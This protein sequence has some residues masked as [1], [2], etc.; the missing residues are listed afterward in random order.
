MFKRFFSLLISS[1]LC[2][3]IFCCVLFGYSIAA[4]ASG[5]PLLQH[6]TMTAQ[7]VQPLDR[8]A[9]AIDTKPAEFSI[10]DV[11]YKVP[12]N[13]IVDMA[14]A[15][16]GPQTLVTFKVTFPGFHPLTD[17]TWDCLS[18]DP[19]RPA[20]GCFQLE[21][22][23]INDPPV[24]GDQPQLREQGGKAH[25]LQSLVPQPGLGVLAAY[26]LGADA[27]RAEPRVDMHGRGR[28]ARHAQMHKKAALPAP[29]IMGCRVTDA[30][31]RKMTCMLEARGPSRNA[32]GLIL[33]GRQPK[34]F[35]EIDNDLKNLLDAFLPALGDS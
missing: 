3:L 25:V 10:G 16:G 6:R 28:A 9:S 11:H 14:Q 17:V 32:V 8:M 27:D 23:I 12:R 5:A 13:Y 4:G 29:E 7:S 2:A 31:R 22:S 18:A 34:D 19:L 33:D 15:D 35:D 26:E 20:N 1:R 24:A 21:F 30:R